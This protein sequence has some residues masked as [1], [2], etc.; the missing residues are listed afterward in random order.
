MLIYSNHRKGSAQIT[1]S[2][3]TDEK[4]P[5]M[6]YPEVVKAMA[7]IKD[8]VAAANAAAIEVARAK[9]RTAVAAT[10]A[11]NGSMVYVARKMMK[12]A[13]K[14]CSAE[15]RAEYGSELAC[16][17]KGTDQLVPRIMWDAVM[18]YRDAKMEESREALAAVTAANAAATAVSAANLHLRSSTLS[19]EV[20]EATTTE[21]KGWVNRVAE[22][23]YS[24]EDDHTWF[25]GGVAGARADIAA[26]AAKV[27]A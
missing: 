12:H 9:K 4:K 2:M 26:I 1:L 11:V 24:Y 18:V 23:A 27:T 14:Q 13:L 6:S 10:E 20:F 25:L 8:A 19:V 17:V 5:F 7:S 3:P 15:M 16:A 22:P 21:D